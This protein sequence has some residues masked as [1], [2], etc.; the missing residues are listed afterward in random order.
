MY[1]FVECVSGALLLTIAFKEGIGVSALSHILSLY[2]LLVVVIIDWKHLVIPN[3]V[4]L[5]GAISWLLIEV[6]E[7]RRFPIESFIS[8]GISFV[9][10]YGILLLGNF[11]FHKPT[12]GFGDVKLGALIGLVLGWKLFLL[13]LW[14][15]ALAGS[16]WGIGNI[17][18]FHKPKDAKLPFG[19]FL[20]ALAMVAIVFNTELDILI[21][22]WSL[23]I[24]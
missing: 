8:A 14:G 7:S 17:V 2:C 5:T 4:I 18:F 22:Q 10:V 1:P 15:A 11:I 24:Q 21:L 19:S 3:Q 9:V 12:M 6:I 20:A 13:V 16:F 23:L